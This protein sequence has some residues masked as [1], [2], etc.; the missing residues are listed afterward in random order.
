MKVLITAPLRQEP[1]VFEAY[2]NS[3]DALR[4]PDGVT[5]DRYFVVND[6]PEVVPLIRGD[7][8]IRNT[9]DVYEKTHDNHIW[10]NANLTKMHDLRQMTIRRA[11]D[12]GYDYFFSID[13]DLVLHP[14]TLAALLDAD[15]DIVSELFWTNNWC[16]AW[17]FDQYG[18]AKPEWA[19]PGLYQVGM[20]GACM[21][22]QRKVLE[23]GVDY[24]PIPNIVKCLWGEDRH[25]CIKAAVMGFELW[26]DTHYPPDHLY[27]EKAYEKWRAENAE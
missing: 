9:G 19:V 7:Y 21:L 25:F 23:A 20:T 24:R 2:Q 3:L 1:R 6:C 13:T 27:T 18:G 15:K 14:E 12:G 26:T 4:I 10:T 8:D 22:V 17:M 11:L 5:V 16:N